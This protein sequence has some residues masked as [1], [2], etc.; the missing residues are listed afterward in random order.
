MPP[1]L[2]LSLCC[3][4]TY[5]AGVGNILRFVCSPHQTRFRAGLPFVGTSAAVAEDCNFVSRAGPNSELSTNHYSHANREV[6]G[7]LEIKLIQY[8][9]KFSEGT[10]TPLRGR[11]SSYSLVIR[12]C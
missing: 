12:L 5:A 3:D 10:S 8:K 6:Q 9:S 2:V 11:P 1:A 7:E 4:A